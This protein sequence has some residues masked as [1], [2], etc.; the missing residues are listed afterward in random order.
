[1]QFRQ[2]MAIHNIFHNIR[3]D[4][5]VLGKPLSDLLSSH[6]K[7][8]CDNAEIVMTS[9]NILVYS[10][11][12]VSNTTVT[13]ATRSRTTKRDNSCVMIDG[14]ECTWGLVQ[15]VFAFMDADPPSYYCL[16]SLLPP[17][18]QQVCDDKVT[19]ARIEEHFVACEPPW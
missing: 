11:L 17:V 3:E 10:G 18:S 14:G 4:Y 9:P 1:M 2:L 7:M 15:K 19:N 12:T 6:E 8:L 16:L 13:S 5:T